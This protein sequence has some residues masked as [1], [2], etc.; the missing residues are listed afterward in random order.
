MRHHNRL[1][2]LQRPHLASTAAQWIACVALVSCLAVI[3]PARAGGPPLKFVRMIEGDN[4]GYRPAI[5]CDSTGNI[6]VGGYGTNA[7]VKLDSDGNSRWTFGPESPPAGPSPKIG[8]TGVA[9]SETGHVY[10]AGVCEGWGSIGSI[11]VTGTSFFAKF[12]PD[13]TLVFLK[14]LKECYLGYHPLAKAQDGRFFLSANL[15]AGADVSYGSFAYQAPQS[16]GTGVVFTLN[17]DGSPVGYQ[18]VVGDVYDVVDDVGAALD[19]GIMVSGRSYSRSVGMAGVSLASSGSRSLYLFV[20][21]PNGIGA[22]GK[23]V[24]SSVD[25]RGFDSGYGAVAFSPR[26]NAYIWAGDFVGSLNLT[27][28]PILSTGGTDAF[29]A[30]ISPNGTVLWATSLGGVGDHFVTDVKVDRFGNIYVGGAF[31]SRIS[32]GSLEVS[33]MGSFDLFVAKFR[34]D[35]TPVWL[36]RMGWSGEDRHVALSFTSAGELAVLGAVTGG[37]S[38]D[39]IFLQS[40][41]HSPRF[42]AVFQSEE[43]PPK[44]SSDPRS[45]VVSAGMRFTLSANLEV[46]DPSVAYQWWLGDSPIPGQTK[47][48][49]TI[50]SAQPSHAG[51]YRLVASNDG[52]STSSASASVTY[53]DS[54]SIVLSVHPSLTIYGATGQGYR[55]DYSSE[56]QGGG[57]WTTA[58]NLTLSVSPTVWIDPTAAVGEKRFYRVVRIP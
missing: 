30:K 24:Q 44:F 42:L 13:G 28:N 47:R 46:D 12:N 26:A 22:F 1:D 17:S 33:S 7:L 36:K 55:I 53:T 58:T 9:V 3:P 8:I 56:A 2:D 41:N 45:Q 11:P 54:A 39:G 52:G 6:Y 40:S 38:I 35:G 16:V 20:A 23:L 37:V 15:S 27:P 49:L 31:P 19:G 14:F 21:R 34:D 4:I 48:V 5:A 50:A 43:I 32:T 25:S 57:Q 18:S 51:S 29:V 10:V